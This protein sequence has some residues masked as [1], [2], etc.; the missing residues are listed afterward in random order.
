[1]LSLTS[2]LAW[3]K[4]PSRPR[5]HSHLPR[6]RVYPR[7]VLSELTSSGLRSRLSRLASKPLARTKVH[8]SCDKPCCQP[9]CAPMR[10][11]FLG[12]SCVCPRVQLRTHVLWDIPD[13]FPLRS[14]AY[15]SAACF[16]RPPLCHASLVLVTF[17][18]C[19]RASVLPSRETDGSF[20]VPHCLCVFIVCCRKE[21][22]CCLAASHGDSA[23]AF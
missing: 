16:A 13:A 4:V 11:A 15:E 5:P 18:V 20:W 2:S 8:V 21:M 17:H 7:H 12:P 22:L 14:I 1:M 19:P 10:C 9:D 3:R 6:H 23:L